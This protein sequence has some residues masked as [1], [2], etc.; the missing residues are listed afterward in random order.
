MKHSSDF[1]FIKVV[2]ELEKVDLSPLILPMLKIIDPLAEVFPEGYIKKLLGR[3][4]P[5]EGQFDFLYRVAPM[6][7][8]AIRLA[9]KVASIRMVGVVLNLFAE[10]MS[11]IL[12]VTLPVAGIIARILRPI[13]V[14][15]AS[16]LKRLL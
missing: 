15:V 12:K 13:S 5:R 6:M 8:G 11:G 4:R 14:F 10:V 3:L 16:S 2:D 1:D 9:G 7:P